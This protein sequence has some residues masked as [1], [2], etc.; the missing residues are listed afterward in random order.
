MTNR[1]PFTEILLLVDSSPSA[2]CPPAIPIVG[3]APAPSRGT[4]RDEG[5]KGG[6]DMRDATEGAADSLQ[7]VVM[8]AREF[9][10]W[11]F[12][13]DEPTATQMN[14]ITQQCRD[15]TIGHTRKVGRCWYINC[16][17]E[18]PELFPRHGAEPQPDPMEALATLLEAMAATIRKGGLDASKESGAA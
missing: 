4:A 14:S 8:S 7:D 1:F 13:C 10:R 6:F 17:E 12:K 9:A 11:H 15:G 3:R 18:W 5:R 2:A 16:T